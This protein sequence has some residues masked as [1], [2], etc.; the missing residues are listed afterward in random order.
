MPVTDACDDD[1]EFGGLEAVAYMI[2]RIDC[3]ACGEVIDLDGDEPPAK[4][5]NETC[6]APVRVT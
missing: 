3:Q 6:G 2:W 5:P 4:C 1:D